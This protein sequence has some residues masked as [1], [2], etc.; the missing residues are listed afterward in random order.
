MTRLDDEV[1]ESGARSD[2]D[3]GCVNFLG[4]L[5]AQQ[6]LVRV[7]TRFPFGLAR[8]R[9]HPDPFQL[10]LERALPLVFLAFLELQSLLL[11]V[12]PR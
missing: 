8:A 6:V 2:V 4:G 5:F 12:E 11:L 9:R 3:F 10:A 7:E 1:A